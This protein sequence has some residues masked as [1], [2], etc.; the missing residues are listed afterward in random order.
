MLRLEDE[1]SYRAVIEG[2]GFELRSENPDK[3]KRYFREIPGTRRTHL[4]VKEA[5]SFAEQATLLLRDYLREHV[6]DCRRC[7]LEKHRLMKLYAD[8][9][10]RYVEGKAPIVWEILHRAHVWAQETGWRPGQSDA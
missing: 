9:R 4:H 1:V 10:P 6:D 8:Q 7:A 3:T 5:G 2:V